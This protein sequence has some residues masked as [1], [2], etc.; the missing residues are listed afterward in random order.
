MWGTGRFE[1]GPYNAL[2][3]E[4]PVSSPPPAIRQV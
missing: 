3:A 4:R 1:T 2:V